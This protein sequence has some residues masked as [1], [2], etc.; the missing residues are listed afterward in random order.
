VFLANILIRARIIYLFIF[1]ERTSHVALAEKKRKLTTVHMWLVSDPFPTSTPRHLL[2][3]GPACATLSLG[4]CCDVHVAVLDLS[5][6][7]SSATV[8][9][10]T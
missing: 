6:R 9:R 7:S 2:S 5:A 10:R 8:V 1:F 4:S 3:S